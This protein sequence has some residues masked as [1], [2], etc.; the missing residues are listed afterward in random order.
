[1]TQGNCCRMAV[2]TLPDSAHWGRPRPLPRPPPPPGRHPTTA[3]ASPCPRSY[4]LPGPPRVP[5]E[6]PRPGDQEAWT[7]G[8]GGPRAALRAGGAGGAGRARGALGSA[9]PAS[10]RS[11]S[12][13]RLPG[14]FVLFLPTT[15]LSSGPGRAQGRG[16]HS[17][18]VFWS[19]SE[20]CFGVREGECP[21][22]SSLAA[23]LSPSL[24]PFVALPAPPPP[25]PPHTH[26]GEFAVWTRSEHSKLSPSKLRSGVEP[27]PGAGLSAGLVVASVSCPRASAKPGFV[28]GLSGTRTSPP[29]AG[30]RGSSETGIGSSLP[31]PDPPAPALCG[32]QLSVKRKLGN[33]G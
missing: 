23:S 19:A 18:R 28:T 22:P 3:P 32:R 29:D 30:S 12:A 33:Q 13:A 8:G 7:C 14:S 24:S 11:G 16:R 5:S 26:S 17:R 4:F 27:P 1:M 20:G 31:R 6:E 9:F 21:P 25:S 15:C 10:G 2:G